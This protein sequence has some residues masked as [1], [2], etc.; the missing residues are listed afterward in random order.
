[1]LANSLSD[2]NTIERNFGVRFTEF[3]RLDY[4]DTVCFSVVDPMHN[5][6]LG[7]AKRMMGI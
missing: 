2:I 5:L 4:F 6:F 3:L 7:T 1:M